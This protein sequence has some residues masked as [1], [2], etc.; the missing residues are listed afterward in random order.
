LIKK[1]HHLVLVQT[2]CLVCIGLHRQR[3]PWLV[4]FQA[5]DVLLAYPRRWQTFS[6]LHHF[7]TLCPASIVQV[8]AGVPGAAD[9]PGRGLQACAPLSAAGTGRRRQDPLRP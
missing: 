1:A 5:S 9:G 6:G 3:A 2:L 7:T 8:Q 4:V